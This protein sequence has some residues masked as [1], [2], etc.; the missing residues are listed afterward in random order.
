MG[1]S[2]KWCAVLGSVRGPV[3]KLASASLCFSG[4]IRLFF[5]NI[6]DYLLS[7]AMLAGGDHDKSLRPTRQRP[8][9]DVGLEV[10]LDADGFLN[11]SGRSAW[12]SVLRFTGAQGC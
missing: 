12:T 1:G 11:G 7:V 5:A 10:G 9:L 8:S 4:E 2:S 3:G 6:A